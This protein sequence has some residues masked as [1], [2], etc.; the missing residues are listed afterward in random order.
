MDKMSFRR[1]SISLWIALALLA[2]LVWSLRFQAMLSVG[3]GTVTTGGEEN[4]LLNFSV[5]RRGEPAYVD[6]YTHPYRNSLF[7]WLYY[8][9]YGQATILAQ[10][11]ELALPTFLRCITVAWTALGVL[12]TLY[13]LRLD[14]PG[15]R[16]GAAWCLALCLSFV[17]WF[18]PTTSWWTMTARPD[19]AAVVCEFLALSAVARGAG[20]GELLRMLVAGLLFFAAWSFKQNEITLLVGTCLALLYRREWL[21][22]LVIA[23][24]FTSL[25]GLV[26]LVQSEAYFTNVF[27][28][29]RLAPWLPENAIFNL[30]WWLYTWGFL[31]GMGM[32]VALFCR[33]AAAGSAPA[34]ERQVFITI[35]AAGVSLLAN[36]VFSAR[37][38]AWSNYFFET[39][40]AGMG[41]TGLAYLQALRDFDAFVTPLQRRLFKLCSIGTLLLA[42]LYTVGL[43]RPFVEFETT[44]LRGEV[45]NDETLA[46]MRESPRPIFSDH[47]ALARLALGEEAGAVPVIDYTIYWDALAKGRLR[48]GGVGE[49]IRQRWYGSLWL[50]ATETAWEQ[51]A[52][53]AG[54]V[55]KAEHGS[56]RQYVRP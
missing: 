18:G 16:N 26:F 20:S 11:T 30:R 53:D 55:L 34:L 8:T 15:N 22:F 28:V 3:P 36:F 24:V 56:L 27:D 38:G 50:D 4:S 17:T 37:R 47:P 32:C 7:N 49:R 39:W 51:P 42:L 14:E 19:I 44:T 25:V 31:L 35:V 45:L 33:P 54:Y 40:I 12:V 2:G 5:I 48:D 46:A 1:W 9:V 13:Y 41:F 21:S 52:R 10:P 43:F 23:G 29:V 6:C